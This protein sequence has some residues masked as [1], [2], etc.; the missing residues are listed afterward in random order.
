MKYTFAGYAVAWDE[1]GHPG[2][3]DRRLMVSRGALN[4]LRNLPLCFGHDQSR[5]YARTTDGSLSLWMDDFGCAVEFQIEDFGLANTISYGGTSGLSFNYLISA[6]RMEET[7]V[8]RVE[9]VERADVDELSIVTQPRLTSAHCW[10]RD[11]VEL[12]DIPPECRYLVR[13]WEDGLISRRSFTPPARG[14]SGFSPANAAHSSRDAGGVGVLSL[15]DMSSL[16]RRMLPPE[17]QLEEI[18]LFQAAAARHAAKMEGR[19]W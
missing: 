12:A 9:I 2:D 6:S 18:R 1:V 19:G 4:I 13:N 3:D 11:F 10:I 5:H 16:R 8:G 15:G 7:D 14:R 17:K